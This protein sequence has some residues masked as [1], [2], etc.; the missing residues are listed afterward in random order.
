MKRLQIQRKK[1]LS[2]ADFARDH[3]QGD[4]LPVIV[5]DATEHWPARSKWTFEF[6]KTAYGSDFATAPLGLYSDV[7]K[8]TKLGAYIDYLDTPDKELPGFWV[9]AKDRR[10]LQIV[11]GPH[12]VLPYL[13]GWFAFQKHPE[14]YDDIK[15]GPYFVNDW[16]LALNPTLR[17]MFDWMCGRQCWAVY[18]G[19]KGA[20]SKLHQDF[21]HSHAYLAQIQGTKRA[22]LFSPADSEFLYRGQVDPEQP[23]LERFELFDRVTAYECVIEPGDMLF[24][25]PD[26]WHCVR[27]LEKSITV[28]HNFF[29]DV[30]IN[31]QMTRLLQRIPK[32]VQGFDKCPE[33]REELRVDWR[34]KGFADPEL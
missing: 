7:A 8:L 9:D 22:I 20:L 3:L 31:E 26:W 33:W 25:P 10:P 29:N 4:G 21:W 32:L 2:P 19:P 11:P 12:A 23:D 27:T 30:N 17:D 14:L 6:F 28:T 15:P 13:L 5:T 18:I 16:L 1:N 34:S 24:I